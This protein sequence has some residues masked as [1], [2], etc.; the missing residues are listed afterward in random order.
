MKPQPG[1]HVCSVYETEDQLVTIVATFLAD[2]LA[3]G[4]R[5]WYVPSGSEIHAVRNAIEQRGIGVDAQARRTA[6]QL[7]DSND[8]YTVRGGFDPEQT[9]RVFS[10]AIEQAL[11][12]GFT[13]FRA[14]AEMSWALQIQNGAES[15]I[16]YEAMLRVLFSTARATGLCLYDRRSMPVRVVNGA[17]LTHPFVA[18]D[19]EF[20]RNAAYDPAVRGLADVDPSSNA[21]R[22]GPIESGTR[23][24]SR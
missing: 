15:L 21:P 19:G 16:A 18:S 5:C 4:E 23:R 1:D 6:L 13:G 22:R 3:R 9:M 24:Q 12:D 11:T 7:L 17:L 8:A 20:R 14:A 2:G 10:D